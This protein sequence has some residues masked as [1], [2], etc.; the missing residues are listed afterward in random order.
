MSPAATPRFSLF[1][2]AA[3]LARRPGLWPTAARMAR[4]SVPSAWWRTAPFL[5]V[6]SRDYVRFRLQTQYGG[7][8]EPSGDTAAVAAGS[9]LVAFLE[10]CRDWDR[11]A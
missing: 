9:D 6:P 10:W 7:G 5:P 11:I 1:A 3:A 2:A 8:T 4:R